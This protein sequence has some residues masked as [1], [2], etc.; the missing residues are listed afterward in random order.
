MSA[1]RGDAPGKTWDQLMA[2]AQVGDANAYRILLS[3][4]SAWLRR[5]FARRLPRA[6]TEDAVED[7]LL[8]IHE[9]RHTYDPTRPF[10]PW[11]A[12]IARCKWTDRLR[13]LKAAASEPL[14]ESLGVAGP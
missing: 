8:A 9:K 14:D 6:M 12:A 7:V 1:K 2:A 13:S 5:H 10:G 11:L 4:L 3:E